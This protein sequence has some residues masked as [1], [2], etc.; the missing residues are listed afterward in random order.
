MRATNNRHDV[1]REIGEQKVG[2]DGGKLLDG[3][4]DEKGTLRYAI[5]RLIYPIIRALVQ[6]S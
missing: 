6:L 2:G 4:E 3:R 1:G 5:P